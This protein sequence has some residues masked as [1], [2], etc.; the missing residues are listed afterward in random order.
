MCYNFYRCFAKTH[1][2][3]KELQFALLEGLHERRDDLTALLLVE[4]HDLF[5]NNSNI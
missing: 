3:E 1:G 2:A 5:A 4:V